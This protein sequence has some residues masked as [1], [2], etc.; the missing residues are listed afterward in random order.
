MC[1]WSALELRRKQRL[2]HV[3]GDKM[4]IKSTSLFSPIRDSRN[5]MFLYVY[6][7]VENCW[8]NLRLSLYIE[9]KNSIRR[10][11]KSGLD[12]LDFASNFN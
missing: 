10:E 5:N 1:R 6:D 4:F 2:I 12:P 3:R 11:N 8:S 9:N 7:N